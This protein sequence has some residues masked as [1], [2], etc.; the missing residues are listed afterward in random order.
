MKYYI[1]DRNAFERVADILRPFFK[2]GKPVVLIALGVT[3][4]AW[5][6]PFVVDFWDFF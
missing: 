6:A 3:L 5:L 2:V 4:G 1:D